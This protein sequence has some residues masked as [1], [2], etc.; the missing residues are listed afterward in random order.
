[1]SE[2][3]CAVIQQAEAPAEQHHDWFEMGKEDNGEVVSRCNRC[4]TLRYEL[5][6]AVRYQAPG[7]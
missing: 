2:P 1:M 7:Q 5:N 6:G 3:N 4:K